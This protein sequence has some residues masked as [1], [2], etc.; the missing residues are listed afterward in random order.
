MK[1]KNPDARRLLY[2]IYATNEGAELIRKAMARGIHRRVIAK[3][4]GVS[5]RVVSRIANGG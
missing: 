2:R 3:A 4:A 1:Q 5:Q